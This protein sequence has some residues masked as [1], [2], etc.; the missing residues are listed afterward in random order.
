MAVALNSLSFA[1]FH[2]LFSRIPFNFQVCKMLK[3]T[4]INVG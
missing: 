4:G 2:I 1:I 3:C